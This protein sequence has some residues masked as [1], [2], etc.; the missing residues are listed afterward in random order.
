MEPPYDRKHRYEVFLPKKYDFNVSWCVDIIDWRDLDEM[1]NNRTDEVVEKS[2][3]W[4]GHGCIIAFAVVGSL[5]AACL[6]VLAVVLTSK[7]RRLAAVVAPPRPKFVSTVEDDEEDRVSNIG[8]PLTDGK[9][10]T[11]P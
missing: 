6:V 5:I 7:R 9:G 11:A 1:L 3:S 4:C 2:L 10:T 8:V